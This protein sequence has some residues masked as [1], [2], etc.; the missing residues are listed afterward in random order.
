MAGQH[1]PRH[2][3]RLQQ[4]RILERA[5][6]EQLKA[7]LRGQV[8][9]DAI[10]LCV[11][12]RVNHGHLVA[13]ISRS[14]MFVEPL[15]MKIFTTRASGTSRAPRRTEQRQ[16]QIGEVRIHRIRAIEHDLP[17]QLSG[18]AQRLRPRRSRDRSPHRPCLPRPVFDGSRDRAHKTSPHSPPQP[19]TLPTFPI[20]MTAILIMLLLAHSATARFK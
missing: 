12:P 10:R 20:P 9:R 13:A 15:V 3:H 5:H 19:N 8:G 2:G 17:R 11:I 14:A 4:S 16:C 6:F 1:H 18:G 7:D